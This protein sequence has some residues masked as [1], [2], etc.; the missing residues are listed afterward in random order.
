MLYSAVEHACYSFWS[1]VLNLPIEQF[2]SGG[3]EFVDSGLYAERDF[4]RFYAFFDAL[5]GTKIFISS[6][7]QIERFRAMYTEKELHQCTPENL[8]KSSFLS[9]RTLLYNDI[10]HYI[11]DKNE[12]WRGPRPFELLQISKEAQLET[13]YADCSEDDVDTLD[14]D[15]DTDFALA[16]IV[17]KQI[18]GVS[19]YRVLSD[20]QVADI[21]LLIRK[22]YRGQGL[23][24]SLVSELVHMIYSANLT[25]RYRAGLRNVVSL[26]VA[27]RL[28]FQRTQQII[29]WGTQ[30]E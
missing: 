24:V 4:N 2:K 9:S 14:L 12:L 6:P 18:V 22:S 19:S 23:A 27:K 3:I 16:A 11:P 25:P 21:T 26:A 8:S 17:D 28:G 7:E 20:T 1:K 29:V 10:E 15:L 30:K 5:F 13:F